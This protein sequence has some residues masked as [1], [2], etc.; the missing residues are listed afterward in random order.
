MKTIMG[1]SAGA[2]ICGLA[3]TAFAASDSDRISRIGTTGNIAYVWPADGEWSNISCGDKGVGTIDTSSESGR[4][5]YQTAKAAFLAQQTVKLY[6]SA[7]D[8]DTYPRI[9]RVDVMAP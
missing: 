7:C 3:A 6:Y 9:T 2:L 8:S 4:L 5:M 1:L